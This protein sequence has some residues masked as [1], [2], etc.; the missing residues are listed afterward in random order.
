MQKLITSCITILILAT[1]AYTKPQTQISAQEIIDRMAEVY[2]NCRTYSDEGEVNTDSVGGRSMTPRRQPFFTAFVRP[3][4]FRFEFSRPGRKGEWDRFIAWKEGDVENSWWGANSGVAPATLDRALFSI[5]FLSDGAALTAPSLLFP[6]L[7]RGR[8][9]LTALD[10]LR[11]TG[12]DKVEGRK[13]FKLEGKFQGQE[14]TLWID[15]REFLIIKIRRKM[16][17]GQF[18]IVTTTRYKPQV[19]GDISHDRLA[20]NPPSDS[21][22]TQVSSANSGASSARLLSSP[23]SERSDI[24]QPPR[25]KEFGSSLKANTK[26]KADKKKKR[27]K[28]DEDDIVRVDTDLVVCDVLVL[29]KQGKWIT[30]LGKDDFVV[31]EDEQPQE[32]GTFSLGDAKMIRRSIVLIIDY[33]GS[34]LPYIKTSIEAAKTLVDKLNPT[35]RV[36]IVTDDVELLVDFTS[37]KALL[38]SRL[39]L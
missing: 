7:F 36:A 35:D 23:V 17:L 4:S 13:T 39:N 29:D 37:D 12:D 19:N 20:F 31:K 18:E 16:K 33:S 11:L 1:L 21:R 2:A 38:K 9:T 27:S 28:D 26:A 15:Q 6:D 32:V 14:L 8:S 25:L 5:S 34:Q 10:E 3:S 24:D 22:A 30:G